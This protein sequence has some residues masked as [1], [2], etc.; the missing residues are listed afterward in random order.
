[1]TDPTTDPVTSPATDPAYATGDVDSEPTMTAPS[2]ERPDGAV[3]P[4]PSDE[5]ADKPDAEGDS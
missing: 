1:M 4:D 2:G 5:Y 3:D